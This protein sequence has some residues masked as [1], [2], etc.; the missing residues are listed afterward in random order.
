MI[1]GTFV[2]TIIWKM[3]VSPNFFWNFEATMNLEKLNSA[4]YYHNWTVHIIYRSDNVQLSNF[5][6]EKRVIKYVARLTPYN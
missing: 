5:V 3:F 2:H 6:S 1:L 4:K